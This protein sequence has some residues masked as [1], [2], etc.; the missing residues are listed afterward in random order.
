MKLNKYVL[1]ARKRFEVWLEDGKGNVEACDY[2]DAFTII[3]KTVDYMTGAETLNITL[4]TRAGQKQFSLPREQIATADACAVFMKYG[5]S[6]SSLN[7]LWILFTILQLQ[8][9]KCPIEYQHNCLGFLEDETGKLVFL[10]YQPIPRRKNIPKNCSKYYQPQRVHPSGELCDWVDFISKEVIGHVNLELALALS[11]TAPVAYLLQRA[12]L[13]SEIPLWALIGKSSTGKTTALK[14]MASVWGSPEE[15]GGMLTDMHTTQNALYALL[16]HNQGIPLLIDETSSVPDW[17]FTKFVYNLPKGHDK[18]RCDSTGNVRE[19]NQF[20]GAVI[21][22][23]ET[24]LFQQ[25]NMNDGL[26]VRLVEFSL[27]W[28]DSAEHAE[29]VE[30]GCRSFYG[31]AAKPIVRW[32]IGH[33]ERI[34]KAYA[35]FQQAFQDEL[36]ADTGLDQR[37]F[38]KYALILTAAY[39]I[40]KA[41]ALGMHRKQL[42]ELLKSLHNLNLPTP[43]ET[44]EIDLAGD[45][46]AE[47]VRETT[48]VSSNGRTMPA[49]NNGK[50][51]VWIPRVKYL[52]ALH[53]RDGERARLN[54]INKGLY[55]QGLIEKFG[56]RY[57]MRHAFGKTMEACYCFY[58]SNIFEESGAGGKHSAKVKQS[59]L[60]MLDESSD[61]NCE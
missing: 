11:V 45:R 4:E 40:S 60:Q 44:N 56:D 14:L 25:T 59:I 27:P 55:E 39:V 61:H 1:T 42:K 17:N 36:D 6:I 22:T 47:Y 32:M 28:T 50:P 49:T 19:A 18:Q 48:C 16:S 23:G 54:R 5:M 57:C 3:S 58:L 30:H 34:G 21:F 43:D 37:L 10:H 29:A 38:K 15:T 26:Y 33:Q 41:T 51:C 31:T 24:S 2:C 52:E 35:S 20:S 9:A 12:K 8:E 7:D 46:L 53:I 13:L